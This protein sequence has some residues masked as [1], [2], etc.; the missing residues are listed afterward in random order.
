[1]LIG[2][3]VWGLCDARMHTFMF[4][5]NFAKLMR[6]NNKASH[7]GGIISVGNIVFCLWGIEP[8]MIPTRAYTGKKIYIQKWFSALSI[9]VNCYID[10]HNNFTIQ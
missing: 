9:E 2:I 4:G 10:S 5:I 1:M 3:Y 7:H 8:T 6:L